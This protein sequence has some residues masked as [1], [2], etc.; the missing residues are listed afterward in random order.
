MYSLLQ[1]MFTMR[2]HYLFTVIIVAA[3]L[4]AMLAGPALAASPT[5]KATATPA[6][7]VTHRHPVSFGY[8]P[9]LIPSR[10]RNPMP[11]GP[12]PANPFPVSK[13]PVNMTPTPMVKYTPGPF[14]I[15][16]PPGIAIGPYGQPVR[17]NQTPKASPLP[18]H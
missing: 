12:L 5:P 16:L 6:K 4:A 7:N 2:T 9:N 10:F 17:P 3:L 14:G 15:S 8:P 1:G 13:L 11:L 18:Q